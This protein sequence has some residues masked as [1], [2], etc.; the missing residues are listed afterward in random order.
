[1]IKDID[2]LAGL[3]GRELGRSD[4]V[5][6]TQDLIDRFAE[7]TGD[8][9]WIHVDAE[10]ASRES[11]YGGTV[12]HGF[13]TL[14][15]L[16]KLVRQIYRVSSMR[17]SINYG[18]NRVRFPAPVRPGSRVRVV[19]DLVG[20]ESIEGGGARITSQVK[21]EIKGAERRACVAETVTLVFP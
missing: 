10:R 7:V 1:M 12:A 17:T 6:I 5:S 14:S 3:K 18:L 15:L 19:V 16:P 20:V 9:Q 21:V 8:D 4:W 2:E 11:R 13:L